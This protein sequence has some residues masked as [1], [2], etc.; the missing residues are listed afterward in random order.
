M[1]KVMA[2]VKVTLRSLNEN[3]VSLTLFCRFQVFPISVSIKQVT[4]GPFRSNGRDG[5]H[6]AGKYSRIR[7]IKCDT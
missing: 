6:L 2:K 1:L 5:S 3:E 4:L 7:P